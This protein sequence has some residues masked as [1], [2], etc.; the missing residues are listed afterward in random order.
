MI[1]EQPLVG[2]NFMN[3]DKIDVHELK[4]RTFDE[5]MWFKNQQ[6]PN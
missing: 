2:P 6:K 4:R 3:S 5:V 1:A